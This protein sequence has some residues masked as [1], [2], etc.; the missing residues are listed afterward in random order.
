MAQAGAQR[1]TATQLNLRPLADEL[2]HNRI[3]SGLEARIHDIGRNP[4]R[5]PAIALAITAFDQNPR[6]RPR[7]T[8]QNPHLVID[9]LQIRDEPQV[10]APATLCG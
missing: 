2:V 3:R 8:I 9:Q 4:H 7:A 1:A 10:F 5:E 6:G